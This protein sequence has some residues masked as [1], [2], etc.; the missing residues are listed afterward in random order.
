RAD[1]FDLDPVAA[2]NRHVAVAA[3][4]AFQ[5]CVA[6]PKVLY[7][8]SYLVKEQAHIFWVRE[9]RLCHYLDKRDT[10]PVVVDEGIDTCLHAA[11]LVHEPA[12]VLLKLHPPYP[13][14]LAI[15]V[16]QPAV[17]SDACYPVGVVLGQ[18]EVLW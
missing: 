15:A 14:A 7:Y 1:V 9:I 11:A 12:G 4:R 10:C 17:N 13:G 8:R 3:N 6:Y 5:L 16:F 2:A 18:L